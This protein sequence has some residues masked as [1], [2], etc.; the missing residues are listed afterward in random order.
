MA[1]ARVSLIIFLANFAV[2]ILALIVSDVHNR[3]VGESGVA[4]CWA[5]S[6]PGGNQRCKQDLRI[7][8]A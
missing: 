8:V 2:T 4:N 5:E 6:S 1:I 3:Y 7:A